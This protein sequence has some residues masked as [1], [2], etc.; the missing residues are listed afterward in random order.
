M[1]KEITLV[2]SLVSLAGMSTFADSFHLYADSLNY[3][4][5]INGGG[6]PIKPPTKPRV[7]SVKPERQHDEYLQALKVRDEAFTKDGTVYYRDLQ[8]PWRMFAPSRLEVRKKYPLVIF[9]HGLGEAG[10]DNIAQLKHKEFMVF[11]QRN[12]Q[13]QRPCFILAPQHPKGEHWGSLVVDEPRR[14]FR[15][16]LFLIGQ[17]SATMP[18]DKTRIYL[19]GL[20]SGAAGVIDGVTLYPHTFAAGVAI[21]P[22]HGLPDLVLLRAKTPSPVW[23][24]YNEGEPADVVQHGRELPGQF[25]QLGGEVRVSVARERVGHNAWQWAFFQKGLADWLFSKSIDPKLAWDDV[26][27]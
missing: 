3:M 4:P 24:C 9:L 2:A 19:L 23:I 18:I 21:S 22:S 13:N 11:A 7:D 16:L 8:M 17:M 10:D 12:F 27:K 26:R 5:R 6:T 25:A 14:V 1:I 20:S 15:M